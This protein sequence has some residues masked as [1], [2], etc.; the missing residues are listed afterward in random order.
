MYK[1]QWNQGPEKTQ[2]QA[3]S[4]PCK[5]SPLEGDEKNNCCAPYCDCWYD[6]TKAYFIKEDGGLGKAEFLELLDAEKLGY[7]R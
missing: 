6:V 3:N 2:W 5:L 1:W 4:M 7:C